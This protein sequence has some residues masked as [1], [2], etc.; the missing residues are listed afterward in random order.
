MV[1][2]KKHTFILFS[3]KSKEAKRFGFFYIPVNISDFRNARA[4]RDRCPPTQRSCCHRSF[5]P[6]LPLLRKSLPHGPARV[7]RHV[8]CLSSRLSLGPDPGVLLGGSSRGFEKDRLQWEGVAA[9][10]RRMESHLL[11]LLWSHTDGVSCTFDW[12]WVSACQLFFYIG[13]IKFMKIM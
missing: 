5:D 2:K 13:L 4:V 6:G 8:L 12:R 3:T 10:R 9:Q 1:R 11:Q 7:S